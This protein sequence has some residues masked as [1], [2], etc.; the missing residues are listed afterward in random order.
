MRR[1]RVSVADQVPDVTTRNERLH[2]VRKAAKRARYAAEAMEP[3]YGRPARQFA[4]AAKR[5][6]SA[7]ALASRKKLRRWLS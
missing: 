7:W 3:V 2:E 1:R 6:Q 5:V 4:K